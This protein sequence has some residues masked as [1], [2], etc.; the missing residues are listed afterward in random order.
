MRDC[1]VFQR[2]PPEQPCRSRS[3]VGNGTA[4]RRGGM[5]WAGTGSCAEVAVR[6]RNDSHVCWILAEEGAGLYN[7][8]QTSFGT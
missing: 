7:F 4:G 3:S 2:S 8:Q 5:G 1:R 6:D